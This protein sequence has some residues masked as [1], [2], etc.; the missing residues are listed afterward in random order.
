MKRF[1]D[2]GITL[3]RFSRQPILVECPFCLKNATVYTKKID[4]VDF[5]QPFFF[6]LVAKIVVNHL[7]KKPNRKI[8]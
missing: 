3:N 6:F 4:D 8:T 5:E 1:V 2:D 7:T